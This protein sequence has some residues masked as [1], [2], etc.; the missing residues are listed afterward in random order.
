MLFSI[1]VANMKLAIVRL[2]GRSAGEERLGDAPN[3]RHGD[4]E[5]ASLRL[6]HQLV[7]RKAAAGT[8]DEEAVE[9]RS[10]EGAA[11]RALRRHGDLLKSLA[12]RREAADAPAIPEG[13]PEA[14][15]RVYGHAV[16]IAVAFGEL[17]VDAAI[18]C[19]AALV[20]VE[21]VDALQCRIRVVH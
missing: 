4:E 11:G 3:A 18:G 21:G 2:P 5:C 19:V 17:K 10:A 6:R 9:L 16:G 1:P 14:V 7:V 13:D 15:L 20:Q 8:G 12:R